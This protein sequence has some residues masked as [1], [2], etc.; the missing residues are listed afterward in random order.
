MKQ[1]TCEV[2]GGNDLLKQDGVFV[3]QSCGCKYSADEVKKLILDV[4]GKVEVTKGD[5]EKER[6]LK[7]AEQ[8]EKF[9]DWEKAYQ[10][11]KEI[12]LEFPDEY[13]GWYKLFELEALK[14]NGRKFIGVSGE[15]AAQQKIDESKSGDSLFSD[16]GWGSDSP[17]YANF[18]PEGNNQLLDKL[19]KALKDNTVNNLKNEIIQQKLKN[20]KSNPNYIKANTLNSSKTEEKLTEFINNCPFDLEIDTYI[21]SHNNLIKNLNIE[22]RYYNFTTNNDI[23]YCMQFRKTNDS[24]LVFAIMNNRGTAI[25]DLKLMQNKSFDL[26][27]RTF[28][29]LDAGIKSIKKMNEAY[30]KNFTPNIVPCFEIHRGLVCYIKGFDKTGY[31]VFGNQNPN[32]NEIENLINNKK[33]NFRLF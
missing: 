32:K 31:Y 3:C 26:E 20:L 30:F 28:K 6:L 16:L 27:L 21:E 23:N 25:Y 9:Q 2:C 7:N 24:S 5:L 4:S 13:L 29:S 15:G 22:D 8:F 11:Y 12:T 1:L 33:K 19:F 18:V 14:Y 10:I 17:A